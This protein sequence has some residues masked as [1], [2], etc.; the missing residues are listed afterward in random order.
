MAAS[1]PLKIDDQT[2]YFLNAENLADIIPPN[3]IQL[4]IT[5][6]P[7]WNAKDYGVPRQI[8]FG[9]SYENY[10]ESL[11]NVWDACI[12]VLK[13]N[14]KIAIDV[15]PL[16]ISGKVSGLKRSS[17]FTI[18]DEIHHFMKQQGMDLSNIF[19]WDKRKYNNQRIFGSYPYP[20]NFF[21][22]IA[23]EFIYIFRKKGKTP[24][25]SKE[26][27]EQSKLTINEWTQWCFNSIWDIPPVIKISP[28]GKNFFGHLAPF[29]EEIPYRLIRL[30]SFVGDHILDPFLGSGTTLKV[31]RSTNR[32]GWGFEINPKYRSIIEARIRE[33]WS[34]KQ[35]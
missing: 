27:K 15:Q 32:I 25:T 11:N 34:P 33:P 16:P 35:Y 21:S 1:D 6:P 2:I 18:I 10:I 7:Y 29:P 5:S 24:K 22:H 12:K 23:F 30:F 19:I 8:G 13:P 31:A 14:G 17:I 28:N 20:P 9:Q 26:I 3:S 4:I